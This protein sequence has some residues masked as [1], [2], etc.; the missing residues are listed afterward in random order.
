MEDV[1]KLN[2]YTLYWNKIQSIRNRYVI[3]KYM[4]Y[5]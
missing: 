5:T 1:D 4:E 3:A 2:R